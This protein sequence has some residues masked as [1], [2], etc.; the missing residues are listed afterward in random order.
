MIQ[1]DRPLDVFVIFNSQARLN[2]STRHSPP[3]HAVDAGAH[4]SISEGP[5]ICP[6]TTW[7]RRDLDLEAAA[8][9]ILDEVPVA[10]QKHPLSIFAV[11]PPHT[12][13]AEPGEG[14]WPILNGMKSHIVS[15]RTVTP[16]PSNRA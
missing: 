11:D 14:Y 3:I 10:T 5:K 7:L 1:T 13:V 2:P 15:V 4:R 9:Q 12:C 8:K 6:R 16:I